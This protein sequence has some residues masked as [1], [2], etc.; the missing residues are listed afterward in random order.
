MR[1]ESAQDG[2]KL[3]ADHAAADDCHLVVM[4]LVVCQ[5]VGACHNARQQ[6]ARKQRPVWARARC[7]QDIARI[8]HPL[9]AVRRGEAH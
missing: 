2:C 7:N 4:P 5:N 8:V 6:H 3:D 9:Y 1:A